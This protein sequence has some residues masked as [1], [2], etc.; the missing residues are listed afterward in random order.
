MAKAG[1]DRFAGFFL[2][3]LA[4]VASTAT[5]RAES[6]SVE[7][8]LSLA[9]ISIG[10]AKLFAEIGS[11]QYKAE[12]SLKLTGLVG[13]FVD[14]KGAA[15]ASG[16]L[17]SGV[18]S[19]DTFSVRARTD[20]NERVIRMSMARGNAAA[21]DIT[22]PLETHPDRVPVQSEHKRGVID[23]LSTVLVP[24]QANRQ[25]LDP[26]N[27]NRTI[28][29]FDGGSRLNIVMSYSRMETLK[30]KGYDSGQALVCAI[31]YVPVSGHRPGRP[32]VRYMVDN[33][34]MW[35]WLAPVSG[36]N[37]LAPLRAQVQTKYGYAIAQAVKW[38]NGGGN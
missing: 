37:V 16:T 27:C 35:I 24:V 26:E 30:V 3:L 6:L 20:S 11:R 13:I 17:S 38:K 25:P 31:R 10:K 29:V 33:K 5:V 23:P 15:S 1:I 34:E 18:I 12:A 36:T 2:G 19:P 32:N 8:N 22:P 7:Y 4:F 14:G 28:P 9:S 21:I